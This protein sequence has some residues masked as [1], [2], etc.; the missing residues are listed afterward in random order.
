MILSRSVFILL[1]PIAFVCSA[2]GFASELCWQGGMEPMSPGVRARG[3]VL[4]ERSDDPSAKFDTLFFGGDFKVSRGV[5]L[6]LQVCGL[7]ASAPVEVCVSLRELRK[8]EGSQAFLIPRRK[9][10]VE[11]AEY[12]RVRIF[13]IDLAADHAQA[14]TS[15]LT[16]ENCPE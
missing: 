9:G 11:F 12:T 10:T 1:A 5:V 16:P 15:A 2:S 3:T 7:M 14:L 4:I 13:D 8:F 6:D